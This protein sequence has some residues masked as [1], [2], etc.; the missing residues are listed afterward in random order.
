MAEVDA[1]QFED[2]ERIEEHRIVVGLAVQLVEYGHTILATNDAL[3]VEIERAC[4][5]P[6]GSLDD[7]REAVRPV[8]TPPGVDT[9]LTFT[10][11]HQ[12]PIAV[13]LDFVNPVRPLR[14]VAGDRGQGGS[15]EA[16]GGNYAR[17]V[18]PWQSSP[19]N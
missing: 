3:A 16:G 6:T 4:L 13:V 19:P 10:L 12:Q 8:S 14:D 18:P 11:P 9:D 1:V 5:Q 7:E 17:S 15:D 2:V